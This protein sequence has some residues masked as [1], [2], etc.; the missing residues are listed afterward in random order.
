[1][2]QLSE[3]DLLASRVNDYPDLAKDVQVLA[4]EYI[5]DFDPGNGEAPVKMI[6]LPIMFSKTPGSIRKLAPEFGEHTEE[7]LLEAGLDWE[8]IAALR[9]IGAIG[10]PA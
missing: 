10:A 3:A 4:N 7:V 8:E 2:K 6:P 9:E 1:V 5:V